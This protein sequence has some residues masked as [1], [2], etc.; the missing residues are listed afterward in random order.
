MGHKIVIE[1]ASE[2]T[3]IIWEH[4]HY[5]EYERNVKKGL[6][7]IIITIALLI[8]FAVIFSFTQ[9]ATEL[10]SK[11]PNTDCE[12]INKDYF[13]KENFLKDDAIAE[14]LMN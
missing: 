6:S 14:F 11:Y 3:D 10:K 12:R 8:S 4:R 13:H 5:T 7:F 1:P 9:K 2:P